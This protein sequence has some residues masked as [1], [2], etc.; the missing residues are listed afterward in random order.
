MDG[1]RIDRK[2]RRSSG[3]SA[4]GAAAALGLAVILTGCA[5]STAR[6]CAQRSPVLEPTR[7]A[8]A[9]FASRPTAAP[10]EIAMAEPGHVQ[11]QA[12]Q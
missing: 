12:H 1:I 9:E 7:T 11:G 6:T 8:S 10:A 3:A 2:K 5:P 4:R